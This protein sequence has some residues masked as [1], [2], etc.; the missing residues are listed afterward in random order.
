MSLSLLLTKASL[1]SWLGVRY[2]SKCSKTSSDNDKNVLPLDVT[3]PE[4]EFATVIACITPNLSLSP[5]KLSEALVLR[6]K[7]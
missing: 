6:S 7:T 5:Q 2:M 1:L 4:W 3:T